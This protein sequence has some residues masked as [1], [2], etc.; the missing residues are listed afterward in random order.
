MSID[1]AKWTLKMTETFQEMN[2]KF[3][4]WE[5]SVSR[6]VIPFEQNTK[7]KIK[8]SPLPVSL[9]DSLKSYIAEREETDN[10]QT[11]QLDFSGLEIS[12]NNPDEPEQVDDLLGFGTPQAAKAP[13]QAQKQ[14]DEWG[15]FFDPNFGSGKTFTDTVDNELAA[16][17][18]PVT[19]EP[20]LKR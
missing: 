1:Q 8:L 12:K 7:Y 20:P 16:L 3:S 14:D 15:V 5:G 11:E 10:I 9:V 2:E 4:T 18:K 6:E 19:Q 13:A 17:S